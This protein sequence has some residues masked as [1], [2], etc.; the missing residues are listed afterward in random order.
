MNL[1][2][3][4]GLR[5]DAVNLSVNLQDASNEPESNVGSQ[6]AGAQ[7]TTAELARHQRRSVEVALSEIGEPRRY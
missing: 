3:S 6:D 5:L 1:E 2:A 4:T 7:T